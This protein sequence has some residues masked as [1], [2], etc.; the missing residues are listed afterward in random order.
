VQALLRRVIEAAEL[1]RAGL[2]ARRAAVDAYALATAGV[3]RVRDRAMGVSSMASAAAT[4]TMRSFG[5][6][7]TYQLLRMF[8][9]EVHAV[10]PRV[11]AYACALGAMGL[12]VSELLTLP[13][14]ATIAQAETGSEWSEVAK[15]S[16]AFALAMPEFEAPRY[17]IWRHANGGGRKDILTFGNPAGVTAMVELYRP[18]SEPEA[19]PDDTTASISELRLSGRPV[20]PI[21]IDTK[22]G[23]IAVDPFTDHAPAGERR[24]LRFWRNFEEPRFEISGWYCNAGPE[25]VDR[26]MIA[27]ALDGLA[28]VAAGGETKIAALFA[29]AEVKRTFCGTNSVF[30]AATPKR[31][32]W[33]EAARDPRLR[34]R[35]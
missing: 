20:L 25:M 33:I 26:G 19:E 1:L 21:A 14:G 18:G 16:P 24:C 9:N 13:R 5:N 29:R 15:P 8:A 17:V 28:L 3:A 27:C 6:G 11:A 34:G 23:E 22:F 32:D 2:A 10:I 30:V 35:Q 4:G 31:H 7:A 12:I